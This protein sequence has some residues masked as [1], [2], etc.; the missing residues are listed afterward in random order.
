MEKK[1]GKNTANG[2]DNK[3][4]VKMCYQDFA[5]TFPTKQAGSVCGSSLG[6]KEAVLRQLLLAKQR[7]DRQPSPPGKSYKF[8][9]T[10]TALVEGQ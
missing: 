9:T 4:K 5:Q 10:S 6:E 3:W 7:L 8:L 2:E 1:K